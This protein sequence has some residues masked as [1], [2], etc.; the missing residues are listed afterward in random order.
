MGGTCGT[1]GEEICAERDLVRK[2]EGK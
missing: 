2:P 1:Y